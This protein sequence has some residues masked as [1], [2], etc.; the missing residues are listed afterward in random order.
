VAALMPMIFETINSHRRIILGVSFPLN[1]QY[2]H[3]PLSFLSSRNMPR[4]KMRIDRDTLKKIPPIADAATNEPL[5]V[6]SNDEAPVVVER[7]KTP[8]TSVDVVI[9]VETAANAP[10]TNTPA[11]SPTA[12]DTTNVDVESINTTWRRMP[13]HL[14][15]SLGKGFFPFIPSA[16]DPSK[17]VVQ[18]L[19]FHGT[20]TLAFLQGKKEEW[21]HKVELN[22]TQE[23]VDK[24]KNFV[25]RSPEYPVVES[26]F[27]W[28]LVRFEN[29]VLTLQFL[30]KQDLKD[31]FDSVWDGR[32]LDKAQLYNI[33]GRRELSCVE[34]KIGAEVMIEAV[35]EIWK[36]PSGQQGCTLHLSAVGLLANAP[37]VQSVSA[38]QQKVLNNYVWISP[39]KKRKTTVVLKKE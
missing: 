12:S 17:S 34:I 18:D 15:S 13:R 29:G 4:K 2:I 16:E 14:P 36:Q 1:I 19:E 10:I 35:P 9:T 30:G 22:V 39:K 38:R 31:D 20:V 27:S 33:E 32:G 24:I 21:S 37:P 7:P 25:R 3:S 11:Q 28:N 26:A 6:T 5:T 23:Y 8:P